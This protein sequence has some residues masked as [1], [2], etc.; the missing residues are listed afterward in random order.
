MEFDKRFAGER[1]AAA[2]NPFVSGSHFVRAIAHAD[3]D[4]CRDTLCMTADHLRNAFVRWGPFRHESQACVLHLLRTAERG[5]GRPVSF[6][7]PAPVSAQ[8]LSAVLPPVPPRCQRGFMRYDDGFYVSGHVSGTPSSIVA[9]S[10]AVAQA[11][12]WAV[13]R[14][15]AQA[16]AWG[17]SSAAFQVAARGSYVR[18]AR[19]AVF[20]TQ[21][22]VHLSLHKS[23]Y[24]LVCVTLMGRFY[25]LDT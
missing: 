22:N 15:V 23:K 12:D 24:G 16:A 20:S 17:R 25:P 21:D 5:R 8:G 6:G 10:G 2:V 7:A 3:V 4:R 14:A 1:L 13:D 18:M 11:V 9:S 19:V